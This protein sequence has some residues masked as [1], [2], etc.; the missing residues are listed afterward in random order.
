M[1]DE[2]QTQVVNADAGGQEIPPEPNPQ[3]GEENPAITRLKAEAAKYRRELS[4]ARAALK[5]YEEA[6]LSEQEKLQRRLAELERDL[7]EKERLLQ[8][9]TIENEVKSRARDIGIRD[10]EIAWRLFDI[11]SVEFGEDGRPTNIEP[12]LK[13][14]V[15]KHPLLA[16]E[17]TIA[18]AG[19]GS[20]S[21]G[22][23]QFTMNDFI[24][25]SSGRK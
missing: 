10:I 9:R 24:R 5:S 11:A 2:N 19:A 13:E 18:K 1:I 25:R 6:K 21:A 23:A 22:K 3:S 15:K 4:E 16:G 20:G 8:E 14:L 7:S 17:G 12:L